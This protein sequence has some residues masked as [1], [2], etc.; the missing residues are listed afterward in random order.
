ML[1]GKRARRFLSVLLILAAILG[2]LLLLR[3]NASRRNGLV[4]H[5]RFG[6]PDV[7]GTSVPDKSAQGN[8]G[9]IN[10]GAR[11]NAGKID[12]GMEFNGVDDYVDSGNKSAFQFTNGDFSM[13]LWFRTENIESENILFGKGG[14]DHISPYLIVI[15]RGSSTLNNKVSVSVGD[16]TCTTWLANGDHVITSNFLKGEWNHVALKK[17]GTLMSIFLNGVLESTYTLSSATICNNAEP[18]RI[19][20]GT[21]FNG[22]LPQ[23]PFRGSIEDSRIYN[24][25]LSMDE[26]KQLYNLGR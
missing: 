1:T 17:K 5:W 25:A 13:S 7:S 2:S 14:T 9:T 20:S 22:N 16:S 10:G 24:R 26:I 3:I 8:H 11:A 21:V 15:N 19:G 18:L 23:Q 4:G 6:G 12:Q